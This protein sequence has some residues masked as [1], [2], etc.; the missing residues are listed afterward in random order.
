MDFLHQSSEEMAQATWIREKMES[1]YSCLSFT[2]R[3]R[4]KYSFYAALISLGIRFCRI[5]FSTVNLFCFFFVFFL[6]GVVEFPS[7][8]PPSECDVE[9]WTRYP[10]NRCWGSVRVLRCSKQRFGNFA[11]A[12]EI[13]TSPISIVSAALRRR[14]EQRYVSGKRLKTFNRPCWTQGL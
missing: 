1:N 14:N 6:V 5:Y 11:V 2:R 4:E 8:I 12:L 9:C 13:M 3:G 10:Y 7:N